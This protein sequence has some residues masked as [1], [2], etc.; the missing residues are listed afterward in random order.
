[1]QFDLDKV[2]SGFPGRHE[3]PDSLREH[4][5]SAIRQLFGFINA[6]SRWECL[7][8]LAYFLATIYWEC[9]YLVDFGGGKKAMYRSMAPVREIG[10]DEYF[11]RRYGHRTDKGKE[12]GN[13]VA[14]DGALFC[15]KG[16][17]Q[18]TG[19]DNAEKTGIRLS[20]TRISHADCLSFGNGRQRALSAFAAAGGTP[21]QAVVVDSQT[22]VKQPDLIL[23][24]KVSYEGAVTGMLEGRYTGRRLGS[25]VNEAKRNF[26]GAR[27]VINGSDHAAE[28]A[29]IAEAMLRMLES[30]VVSAPATPLA[31]LLPDPAPAPAA[32]LAAAPAVAASAAVAVGDPADVPPTK[33]L[34]FK[35]K[36]HEIGGWFG[37]I[38]SVCYGVYDRHPEMVIG[39]ILVIVALIL[40][41]FWLNREKLLIASDPNRMNVH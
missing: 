25:Y 37:S 33:V 3:V 20:G 6:D 41:A 13:E 11:E 9:S 2:L 14:G 28:I 10:G 18:E 4:Q 19:R 16:Y 29:E 5:A 15:G 22:F 35:Q 17:V 1:M 27:A 26:R 21:E 36:L 39:G 24:P 40:G 32:V 23:V 34:G 12:L 30:S 7:P 31:D 38:G 8:P